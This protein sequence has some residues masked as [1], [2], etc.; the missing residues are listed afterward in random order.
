MS[1][2]SGDPSKTSSRF[3][4]EALSAAP[5]A[6]LK[7][8]RAFRPVYGRA[9]RPRRHPVGVCACGQRARRGRRLGLAFVTDVAD[10]FAARRLNRV[11][12]FGS[13]FDSLVDSPSGRRQSS[14][15][16]CSSLTW[17][18]DHALLAGAWVAVTYTSLAVGLVR[19]RRFAN[20]TYGRR[21]SRASP[22]RVPRRRLCC[23]LV[24][25]GLLYLAAGL[26]SSRPWRRWCSS[27]PSTAS[28]RK[29]ARI[30]RALQRRRA[31]A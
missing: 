24:Q 12:P 16:C 27:S 6:T 4:P 11:T 30:S 20:L 17:W 3:R 14:G 22:V 5:A 8:L 15:C 25:P 13:R 31:V 9:A 21:G 2:T 29:S 18:R 28:T 7:E 23:R 26:G 19:H 10:G 1:E